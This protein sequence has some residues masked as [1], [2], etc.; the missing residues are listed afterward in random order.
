MSSHN[1][2]LRHQRKILQ[3]LYENTSLSVREISER[4]NISCS[5]VRRNL[6]AL[7]AM[8]SNIKKVHGG[9]EI[10]AFV[11]HRNHNRNAVDPHLITRAAGK[12]TP[13]DLVYLD[14]GETALLLAEA[15]CQC[16]ITVV[17]I[18][19][20]IASLMKDFNRTVLIGGSMERNCDFT[21]GPEA[22]S[23][24]AQYRFDVAF[25]ST[26]CFDLV[27]GVT[28]PHVDNARLKQQV[29]AHS[30]RKYLIAEGH[31]FNKFSLHPVAALQD[32]DAIITDGTIP[33]LTLE[34]LE[35]CAVTLE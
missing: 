33:E 8:Y 20:K 34:M 4:L 9:V 22:L 29:L 15:I 14:S 35:S 6:A 3:L 27:H 26:N 7:S 2:T 19:L 5:T 16:S 30:A 11:S 23:Q 12:V 24:L 1:Q 10:D 17:T 31:K 28:A 13:G 25:I 18:D 21:T 32:F